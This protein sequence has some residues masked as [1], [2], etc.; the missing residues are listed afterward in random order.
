MREYKSE[1][2]EGGIGEIGMGEA[3][4]VAAANVGVIEFICVMFRCG[5]TIPLP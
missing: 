2:I 4:A 3:G 1:E 5:Y